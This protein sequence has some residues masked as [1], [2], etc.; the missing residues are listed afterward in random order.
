M[1]KLENKRQEFGKS[2]LKGADNIKEKIKHLDPRLRKLIA[3]CEEVF[4]LCMPVCVCV[5]VCVCD[6]HQIIRHLH[7]LRGSTPMSY[8][9]VCVCVCVYVCVCVCVFALAG[10]RRFVLVTTWVNQV[11]PFS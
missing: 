4:G 7:K 9:S 1:D 2:N 5:C 3:K 6:A 10:N 8:L 11:I